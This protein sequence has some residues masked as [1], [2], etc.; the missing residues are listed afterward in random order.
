MVTVTAA[1]IASP[2]TAPVSAMTPDGISAASTGNPAALTAR[3]TAAAAPSAARS[4]PMPNTASS[5]A[6]LTGRR[7]S[8]AS[9]VQTGTPAAVASAYCRAHSPLM[10]VGSGVPSTPGCPRYSTA[11]GRAVQ[12]C[13]V[14]SLRAAAKPSP[15]LLPPP[16][17]IS[18]CPAGNSAGRLSM[19]RTSAAAARSIRIWEGT[20][21]SR[22]VYASHR[23]ICRAVRMGVNARMGALPFAFLFV[24]ST[25]SKSGAGRRSKSPHPPAAVYRD[26]PACKTAGGERQDRLILPVST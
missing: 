7:R 26:R 15:P 10:R 18:T 3:N 21:V 22:I 16:H 24:Y 2:G 20:P 9:G 8:S 13:P 5:T 6:V 25:F 4:S 19:Q 1:R 17:R 23:R 11:T 14:A 12:S